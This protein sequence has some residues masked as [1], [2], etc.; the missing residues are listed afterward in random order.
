MIA[1]FA[2]YRSWIAWVPVVSLLAIPLLL[3]RVAAASLAM[4]GAFLGFLLVL[5]APPFGGNADL[6]GP[7]I[8]VG[9]VGGAVVGAL[10]GAIGGR[11]RD[12]GPRDASETIVGWALGLGLVGLVVGGFAPGVLEGT[13]PDLTVSVLLA[14]AVGGGLGWSVGATIGWRRARSAPPPGQLQRWILISAAASVAL[15]GACIVALIQARDFGPPID[16]MTR[17]QVRQLPLIAAL[18][19]VDTAIAV[20]TLGAVAVRGFVLPVPSGLAHEASSDP[21]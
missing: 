4:V 10:L 14:V 9:V 5:S 20:M 3:R 11:H 6:F 17:Q 8:V 13:P 15:F 19:C 7:N 18:Y 21:E 1:E 12:A 16:S 2:S